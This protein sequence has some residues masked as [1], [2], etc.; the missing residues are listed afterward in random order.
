VTPPLIYNLFPRLLGPTSRWTD[1]TRAAADM[2]FDWIYLNPWHYPG[3]SGSLYAPKEYRRMNPLFL[4]PGADERSLDPLRDYLRSAA[5]LGV[6]VMMDLVVNHT[7]KDSPLADEHPAWYVRDAHGELVSPSVADPDDPTN[8]TVWGDLAEID[9]EGSADRDALWAYWGDLVEDSLR[10]GFAGFRCDAAYMV[11]SA[12]WRYLI[13]RAKRVRPDVEFFGETLGASEEAVH[14]LADSGF[15]YFFNSSKWWDFRQS[16]ALE[17][18]EAFGRIAPSISFPETHD[19]TRLAADTGGDEAVQRQRYA[20]ATAFSAGVM[21]PIGYEYGFRKKTDVVHTMPS[22]W[23]RRSFDLRP[24]VA[25]ANRLKREHPLL[26][27]EG[28]LRAPEGLGQAVLLLERSSGRGR[29]GYIVVNTDTGGE[30]HLDLIALQESR[31]DLRLHRV[32]RDDEPDPRPLPRHL[33]LARGEIVFLLPALDGDPDAL[34]GS[35]T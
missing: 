19:T 34:P 15:H 24:F 14:D 13:G 21:M 16:W 35:G 7:S 23:E 31:E 11:P 27:G 18:H 6:R 26:H 33:S 25:R 32:C 30:H 22:D 8:V 4:P 28:R 17:Q 29:S 3:F 20:L 10:L 9:N 2:G 12:L 5:D 1:A